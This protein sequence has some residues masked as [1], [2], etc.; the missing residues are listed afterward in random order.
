MEIILYIILILLTLFGITFLILLP[1]LG[2][3]T[4]LQADILDEKK[5]G[6]EGARYLR[7]HGG[8]GY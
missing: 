2:F 3:I 4:G 5:H 1:L 8:R 7:G 6:L